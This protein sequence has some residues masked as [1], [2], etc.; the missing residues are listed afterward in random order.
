MMLQYNFVHN[1]ILALL[2]HLVLVSEGHFN[3][4]D[5]NVLLVEGAVNQQLLSFV[6]FVNFSFD[7]IKLSIWFLAILGVLTTK[8][9]TLRHVDPFCK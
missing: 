4:A 7:V 1:I 8:V 3:F 9:L 5:Q 6:R 2:C